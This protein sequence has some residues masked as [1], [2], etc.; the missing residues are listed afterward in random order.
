MG[1]GCLATPSIVIG[2]GLSR[3]VSE[4]DFV[5][6]E[7][8]SLPGAYVGMRK[9]CEPSGFFFMRRYG[10]Q[11]RKCSWALPRSLLPRRHKND[12]I[13]NFYPCTVSKVGTYIPVQYLGCS[14]L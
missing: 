12:E 2:P 14:I 6:N 10:V 1:S 9:R 11:A 8:L 7:S 5:T 13:Y 4:D 3:D